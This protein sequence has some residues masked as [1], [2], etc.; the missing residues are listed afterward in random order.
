[1]NIFSNAVEFS[2]FNQGSVIFT[3]GDPGDCAYAV[4]SGEVEILVNGKVVDRVLPG[5]IFG[6]MALIDQKTRSASVIAAT[7][8]QLVSI[9]ERQFY[10]LVQ[11]TPFFALEVMRVMAERLRRLNGVW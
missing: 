7:D 3:E 1:M 9:S 8:C 2:T 5:G 11:Q 10:L 6:E 4:K